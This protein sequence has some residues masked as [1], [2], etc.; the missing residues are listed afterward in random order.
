MAG[1]STSIAIQDRVTGSLNRITAALYNSTSAFNA[2]DNASNVAFNSDGVQAMTNEMYHYNSRI[3]QLEAD[4]VDANRRLVE[5]EEQTESTAKSADMLKSAFNAVKGVMTGMAVKG[6]LQTSDEL[7]QT[8][9][10]IE[11]MNDGLQTTDELMNMVYKS[12]QDAR[13]SFGDMA[14]VVARFGNNVGIGENKVFKSAEEVVAF[15]NIIQKQMTIA[16]ASTNEASNAMVQLSQALGSGALRGD[17]LNSIFEQSPNLIQNIAKYIQENEEVARSMAA[18]AKVSYEEMSTNA[19]GH[20]RDLAAEGAISANLVKNA[21]FSAADDI[22]AQFNSMPM[23]WGQI[24]QKMQNTA[25][26]SFRPVL[27]KINELANSASFQKFINSVTTAMAK[28]SNVVINIFNLVATV[29]NFIAQNWSIISPIIYGVIAALGVYLAYLAI[30]KTAEAVGTA[31]KIAMCLASY[32]KAAATGTEAS[33]TA[34]ATAAQHGF[35]TALLSCPL[36]WIALAIMAVIVVIM[37]LCNWIAKVTG[38]ASTGFGI[39]AGGINVVLQFFKNLGLGVANIALGIWNALGACANNVGTVFHNV[40]C[41]IQSWFYGLLATVMEVVEG[42]CRTLNKVPFVSIDYSGIADRADEYAA[43]AAEAEGRKEDYTNI[44]DAF[45]KGMSTFDTFQNGWVS[46]AFDAGAS[47][48]DGVMNNLDEFLS[49]DSGVTGID[50]AYTSTGAGSMLDATNTIADNTGEALDISNENLKYLRDIAETET[51]N[52]FTT[53]EI[54]V[55]MK[56]NNNINSKLDIDG[57]VEQ[58]TIGVQEA[59][60]SAAEGVYA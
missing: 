7:V 56:N 16:G 4:L 53:A 42:V 54:K 32:A 55:D 8:T 46:E 57:I 45:N 3:E 50:D 10:R 1:I 30:T 33:A 25:L 58:L 29:G 12:A 13:G 28:I 2:V 44:G 48:G 49:L 17:E 15:S 60:S 27:N 41:N 31:I 37:M 9:S 18:V 14:D 11:M 26:M 52:R 5:M 6:I 47:W 38:A 19:M 35:N 34:A 43:K 51:I 24:W 23:T 36:V 59:M 22:D 20:I 40:I 21:M 39:I